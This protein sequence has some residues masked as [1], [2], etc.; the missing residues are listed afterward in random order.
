MV[1]VPEF[2]FFCSV[3]GQ[4]VDCLAAGASHGSEPVVTAQP[5]DATHPRRHLLAGSVLLNI[6]LAINPG[7]ASPVQPG[8]QSSQLGHVVGRL[9]V[10]YWPGRVGLSE[11]AAQHLCQVQ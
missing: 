3:K 10:F 5:D 9:D 4:S 6:A 8:I 2:L 1:V 11:M 7:F